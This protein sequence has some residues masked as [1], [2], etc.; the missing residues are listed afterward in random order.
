MCLLYFIF[1]KGFLE[2][3]MGGIG[4]E[5]DTNY[6]LMSRDDGAFFRLIYSF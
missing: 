2:N 4:A 5:C 1:I 6:V 3:K